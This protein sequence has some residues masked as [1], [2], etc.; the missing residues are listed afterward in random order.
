[1]IMKKFNSGVALLALFVA[2]AAI[3]G[4]ASL[5]GSK[6]FTN[7]LPS[8]TKASTGGCGPC[9]VD[10]TCCMETGVCP[11]DACT[12]KCCGQNGCCVKTA[13]SQAV[14]AMGSCCEGSECTEGKVVT[15]SAKSE[16]CEGKDG[17]CCEGGECTEG[18]V[19]TVSAKSECCKESEAASEFT[20]NDKQ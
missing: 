8:L 7:I 18:K 11:C 3:A 20:A 13:V 17:A 2:V 10:G 19:V 4:A 14:A 5:S 1:M 16:C 15:A 12:C 6:G 9:C